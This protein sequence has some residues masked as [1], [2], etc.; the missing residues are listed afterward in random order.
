MVRRLERCGMRSI[1]AIVDITNFVMLELGQPLHAFDNRAIK[2]EVIVRRARQGERLRLLNGQD[3]ELSP[4][5]LLIADTE[6]PLAL[7]GVMGGEA[8]AVSDSTADVFLEAAWF[9]PSAVAGRARRFALSSDAAFRFERRVDFAA[10]PEGIERAPQL[11]FDICGGAAGPKTGVGA[12][13]P[14]RNPG[15]LRSSRVGNM[16]DLP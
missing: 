8:S 9:D 15:R 14:P 5:V 3:I 11:I 2:G 1:S 4:D 10:T 6:K 12:G 16:S 13:R 7:G